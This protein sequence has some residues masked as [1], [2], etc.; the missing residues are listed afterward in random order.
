MDLQNFPWR[1]LR[2]E[3]ASLRHVC[4]ALP[5]TDSQPGRGEVG[6]LFPLRQVEGSKSDDGHAQS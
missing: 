6:P 2:T 3:H 1:A 5:V 4:F